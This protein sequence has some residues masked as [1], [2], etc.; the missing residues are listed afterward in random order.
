M[1]AADIESGVVQGLHPIVI[2]CARAGRA[3]SRCPTP[4][5]SPRLSPRPP[6]RSLARCGSR[7][8]PLHPARRRDGD[9]MAA[10]E[11]A[12]TLVFM[13]AP[14]IVGRHGPGRAR[15]RHRLVSTSHVET[16][17]IH[18]SIGIRMSRTK[19][20]PR[21]VHPRRAVPGSAA[22]ERG[23]R[24]GGDSRGRMGGRPSSIRSQLRQ[25]WRARRGRG[26]V[27]P[28]AGK[29]VDLWGGDSSRSGARTPAIRS[30]WSSAPARRSSPSP[31]PCA[32]ERGLAPA[33]RT[34]SARYWPE[35]AAHGKGDATVRSCS[36]TNADS[37][38]ADDP[39][40]L[41]EALDWEIVTTCLAD[42]VAGLADRQ[43]RTDITPSRSAGWPAS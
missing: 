14:S 17:S 30:N 2:A 3:S 39:I 28:R 41:K 27:P 10:I 6:R 24:I 22:G 23:A 11:L 16:R 37:S 9:D 1:R 5:G 36:A 43:R 33:T 40:T 4:T 20:G 19:P 21:R 12:E 29:V 15:D 42:T 38:A 7:R 8:R 25:R 32:V 13:H 35:F 26:R 18:N 31:S 34:G